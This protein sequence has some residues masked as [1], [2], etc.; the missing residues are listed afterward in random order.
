MGLLLWLK[1]AT[2]KH[3]FKLDALQ[4]DEERKVSFIKCTKCIKLFEDFCGYRILCKGTFEPY[5]SV[6]HPDYEDIRKKAIEN[7]S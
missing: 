6:L 3:H 2:C 1:Q 5:T 4:R 7:N